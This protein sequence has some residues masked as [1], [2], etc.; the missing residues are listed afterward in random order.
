MHVGVS[1]ILIGRESAK[2]HLVIEKRKIAKIV[3]EKRIV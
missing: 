1:C 3:T 2:I